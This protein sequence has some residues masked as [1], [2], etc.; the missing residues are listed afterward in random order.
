MAA[1]HHGLKTIIALQRLLE[2]RAVQ[3]DRLLRVLPKRVLHLRQERR[4]VSCF[5]R[6][7]IQITVLHQNTRFVRR[8]DG[9]SGQLQHFEYID[10]CQ[11][12][13]L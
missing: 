7:Q 11:D 3:N 13:L 12:V 10:I 9:A 5:V 4:C 1:L 6:E 2:L 8:N